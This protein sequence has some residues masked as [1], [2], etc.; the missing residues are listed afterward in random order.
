M[1]LTAPPFAANSPWNVPIGP[2]A[3]Y[4]P[5]AWPAADGY[6]YSVGWDTYSVGV[7]VAAPTDPLVSVTQSGGWGYP[8]GVVQ[9]HMPAAA[10]GAAGTDGSAVIIDNG[11]SYNFWQL[12]RATGATTAT[13]S[14]YG[15]ANITT[16]T[17][18]GSAQPFL[19]AGITAIGDNQLGGLITSTDQANGLINHGLSI[20]VDGA[21]LAGGLA[22]GPGIS[23]D[24]TPGTVGIV[25]QGAHLAIPPSVPMPAGLSALG[26][27]VFTALQ[28]YGAYVVDQ[29]GGVTNIAAQFNAFDATTI[30]AL[31]HDMG[32]IT[33]LLEQVVS[34]GT[35]GSTGGTGSTGSTGATGGTIGATGATGPKGATGATGATSP[36]GATGATGTKGATGAT[37][38]TGSGSAGA[39]GATGPAGPTGPSATGA[40]GAS[41]GAFWRD[42]ATVADARAKALGS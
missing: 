20:A 2:G 35:A 13:A 7:Y 36:T 22:P 4:K 9:V 5:I 15:K 16:D 8:A 23:S 21:L 26:Q 40:S 24:T 29:A 19:G 11:V 1:T 18:F 38:P 25:Q 12:V 42:M 10:V 27:Q 28:K 30:T 3:T 39:T 34:M 6:N 37:G 17:G 14:A 32:N 41:L 33:P 31:W